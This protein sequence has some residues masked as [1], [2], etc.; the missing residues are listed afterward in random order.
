M[1]NYKQARK[2]ILV[3]IKGWNSKRPTISLLLCTSIPI[4]IP[5]LLLQIWPCCQC[6]GPGFIG[7][8]K[9][10]VVGIFDCHRWLETDNIQVV[11]TPIQILHIKEEMA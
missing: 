3:K 11:T 10:L 8:V 1:T 2:G 5:A 4:Q 6:S 9:S 7:S